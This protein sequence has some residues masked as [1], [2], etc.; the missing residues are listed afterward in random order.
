MN[1]IRLAALVFVVLLFPA[2]YLKGCA[3]EKERFD[4]FKAMVE[5]AGKAQE[6][7]TAARIAHDGLLKEEADEEN[8]MARDRLLAA[9]RKLRSE[10]P[11]GSFVP[12]AASCTD[13]PAAA[14]LDRAILERA[15]RDL[16]AGVQGLVDEGSSAVTDLDSAKRWAHDR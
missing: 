3:D 7:R 6:D 12:A 9:I 15:I 16:D 1:Y 4:D 13:R 5:A 10:R 8:R 2:G 14:C 11:S